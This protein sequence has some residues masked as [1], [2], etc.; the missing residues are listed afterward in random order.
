MKKSNFSKN[1]YEYLI[2]RKKI[3]AQYKMNYIYQIRMSIMNK[4]QWMADDIALAL[5]FNENSSY[6]GQLWSHGY[7]AQLKPFYKIVKNTISS[8]KGYIGDVLEIP[9]LGKSVRIGSQPFGWR[10]SNP[11]IEKFIFD[12]YKEKKDLGIRTLERV[13]KR[14]KKGR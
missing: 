2:N 14:L 5:K 11:D 9:E 7:S 3:E 1:E 4:V 8:R 13:L 10:N 12:V 6:R